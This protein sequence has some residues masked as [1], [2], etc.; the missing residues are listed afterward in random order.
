MPA[1]GGKRDGNRRGERKGKCAQKLCSRE[2]KTEKEK[3]G[4]N[5]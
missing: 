1:R 3:M 2:T 5:W 4:G